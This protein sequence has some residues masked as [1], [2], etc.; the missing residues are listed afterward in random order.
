LEAVVKIVV[1]VAVFAAL[2]EIVKVI[3]EVVVVP[4]ISVHGAFSAWQTGA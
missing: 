4:V 3:P 1:K 2:F